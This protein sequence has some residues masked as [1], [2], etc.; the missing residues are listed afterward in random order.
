MKYKKWLLKNTQSLKGKWIALS[1]AT[2]GLGS[3]IAEYV[4]YL[5]G[6]LIFL[7]RNLK[8]STALKNKISEKYKEI[9]IELITV[10]MAEIDTVISAAELLKGYN[11]FALIHNAGAYCIPRYKCSTGYD[12]VFQINFISPYYLTRELMPVLRKNGGR[13]VTVGSI[14]HNYSK[15]DKTDIDFKSRT[16]S[17][18]VYGNSKRFLMF[19]HS[20]LFKNE[21][22]VH[23]AVVHP[24]ITFTNITAHYPKLIFAVIKYPMKI[25]FMK[26]EA[27]AL[28]ILSGL[29]KSTDYGFWIGPEFFN[30]WGLPT[31]KKL[32]TCT[33][34]E[35]KF[36]SSAAE[37]IYKNIKSTEKQKQNK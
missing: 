29:F 23:L 20:E 27:A 1:G 37:Y 11:L 25:I 12:N 18:L 13:V 24:G 35:S 4:A 22:N 10:D 2:G 36:I 30:V 33:T 3:K 14:A 19:A 32:K 15:T 31:M 16:K 34:D 6:N 17:S 21:K 26:P 9:S 28:S 5:D 8:R 7:D